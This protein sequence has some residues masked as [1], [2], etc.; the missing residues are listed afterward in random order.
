MTRPLRAQVITH[1]ALAA[2]AFALSVPRSSDFY[3]HLH[4]AFCRAYIVFVFCRCNLHTE[5][6]L[7]ARSWERR[8]TGGKAQDAC[9]HFVSL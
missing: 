6:S 5:A 9:A 3:F 1:H 4:C 2:T 8:G 7:N